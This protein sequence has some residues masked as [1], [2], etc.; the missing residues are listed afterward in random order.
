MWRGL[1][2]WGLV[3]YLAGPVPV[4]ASDFDFDA[5]AI[6]G[7]DYRNAFYDRAG[8]DSDV[9]PMLRRLKGELEYDPDNPWRINFGLDYGVAE[10][11]DETDRDK[12]FSDAYVRYEWPER[13][14]LEVGHTREP[15][16]FERITGRSRLA[17]T[18]RSM[19]VEAFAPGRSTGIKFSSLSEFTTWELGVFQEDFT[20]RATRAVTGRMTWSPVI[21][22]ANTL[23]LGVSGSLRDLR[24]E[25]FQIR[26]R[27]E[28]FEGSTVVRSAVFEADEARLLG[29]EVMWQSHSFTVISELIAQEV[30]RN[31]GLSWLYSGGYIQ[32]QHILTGEQRNYR[33]G[34][35]RDVEPEGPGGAW[36]LVGRLSYSDFRDNSLGS[37][38]AVGLAGVNYYFSEDVN[39]KLHYLRSEITGNTLHDETLGHAVIARLQFTIF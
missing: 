10:F 34:S 31:D 28:V 20:P 4:L 9:V 16:S 3:L 38:A 18:E 17:T 5:Y 22:R 36:E 33:R 24:G 35:L 12:G 8:V 6:L 7:V 27:G 21:E 23:H 14:Q 2:P 37:R 11:D 30:I 15:F 13:R 1:L 39:F 29:T 25:E 32:L 26:E 19:P